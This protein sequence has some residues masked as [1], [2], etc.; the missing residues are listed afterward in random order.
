MNTAEQILVIFLSVAL[1]AFLT[2]AIILTIQGIRLLK[3]VQR[4]ADKAE[5]VVQTAEHVGQVLQNV[6]GPLG[7]L[8]MIKNIMNVS[9]KNNKRGKS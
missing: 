9:H 4:I 2:L 8:N 1:A 7:I 5:S 6:S 3:T